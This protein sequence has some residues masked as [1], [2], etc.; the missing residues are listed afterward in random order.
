MMLVKGTL[1]VLGDDAGSAALARGVP[2]LDT[3]GW[4]WPS[5]PFCGC[6]GSQCGRVERTGARRMLIRVH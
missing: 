5:S 1:V 6:E 3:S 2:A 4:Q